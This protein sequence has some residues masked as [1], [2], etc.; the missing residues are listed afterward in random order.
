MSKD[1]SHLP[2]RAGVG[3]MLLNA[4]GE[5]FVAKRIDSVAEAWQM[6]QGGM[7]AGETPEAAARR[8]L[9]EETGVTQAVVLAHT[10]DWKYYD[11]P[12]A[13]VPKIWGGKYR[14]Q[15]Q[16]WFCMRFTGVDADINIHGPH[17]EFSQW[18]WVPPH[19]LPDLIVPFKRDLYAE[20]VAEFAAFF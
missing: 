11:L 4:T 2:Y 14:G 19:A 9:Q 8:E 3:V 13:L 20:L 18:R 16:H 12:D 5:V 1:F 17:P 15:K 6:P 10:Q 7:D